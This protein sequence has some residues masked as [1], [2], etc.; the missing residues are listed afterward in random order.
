LLKTVFF[1]Q[2]R[3][4]EIQKNKNPSRAFWLWK[5]RRRVSRPEV[6]GQGLKSGRVYFHLSKEQPDFSLAKKIEGPSHFF[7]LVSG[8]W[9]I[10]WMITSLGT[11]QYQEQK[12]CVASMILL[13]AVAMLASMPGTSVQR[14]CTKRA[15]LTMPR[16]S[17]YTI[18][19]VF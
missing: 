9:Q 8:C 19:G 17:K 13:N 7:T 18:R 12:Y 11:S 16:N 1:K 10:F 15:C 5:Y 6:E 14:P 3:E 2:V 4:L